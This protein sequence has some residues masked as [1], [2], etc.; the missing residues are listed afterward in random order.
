MAGKNNKI[1]EYDIVNDIKSIK[2]LILTHRSYGGPKSYRIEKGGKFYLKLHQIHDVRIKYLSEI[3]KTNKTIT[4]LY[5][6]S[7][8]ISDVGMKYLSNGLKTNQAI[9]KI[10]IIGNGMDTEQIKY[11]CGGLK[12]NKTISHLK[13]Q[14]NSINNDGLKYLVETFENNSIMHLE[15]DYNN[16]HDVELLKRMENL[17]LQK[18][19]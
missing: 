7:S 17:N 10:E 14:D 13:I 6:N 9:T 4:T 16:N 5:L 11:L 15:I 2:T 1:Y 19:D 3:L 8:Q 18:M 12:N